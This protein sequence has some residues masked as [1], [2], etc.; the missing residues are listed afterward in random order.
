MV[1]ENIQLPSLKDASPLSRDALREIDEWLHD[2][3]DVK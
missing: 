3:E 1:L 2:E